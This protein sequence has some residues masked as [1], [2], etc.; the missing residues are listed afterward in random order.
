MKKFLVIVDIQATPTVT[1]ANFN[2][3][4]NDGK[5]FEPGEKEALFD[6]FNTDMKLHFNSKLEIMVDLIEQ[7]KSNKD[8][9]FILEDANSPAPIH[10]SLIHTL[11]SYPFICIRKPVFNGSA[12]ILSAIKHMELKVKELEICGCY[13]RC[14]VLQTVIGLR[15]VLGPEKV[16]VIANACFDKDW[17]ECFISDE[18][19]RLKI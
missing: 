7:Y 4:R 5:P 15:K 9:I 18:K 3:T 13:T 6:K 12:F 17:E 16:K 2:A 1:I 10:N 8:G 19:L 11:G 14:C